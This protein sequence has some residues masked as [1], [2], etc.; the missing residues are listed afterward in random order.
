MHGLAYAAAVLVAAVFVRAAIAKLADRPGTAMAFAELGVPAIAAVVV[1]MIEL[2]LAVALVLVPGW[3]AT[4]ALALLAAFTTFLVL[5]VRSGV[6]AGCNCF[7]NAR[8]APVSWVDV[9]R[10][11]LLAAF[12][13]FAVSASRPTVPDSAAVALIAGLAVLASGVVKMAEAVR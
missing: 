1:P 11:V 8:R 5:A 10:N 4:F 13:I 2:G 6:R 3:G 7:G 12:A 9:L